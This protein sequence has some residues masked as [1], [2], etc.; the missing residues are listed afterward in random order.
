MPGAKED[1]SEDQSLKTRRLSESQHG[2]WW[3]LP[4]SLDTSNQF[5]VTYTH[6]PH[7]PQEQAEEFVSGLNKWS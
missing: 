4:C 2:K 1:V 7:S 6:I 3:A 5:A